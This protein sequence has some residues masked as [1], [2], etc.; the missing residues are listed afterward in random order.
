MIELEP[1][2]IYRLDVIGP[3]E[4]ADGAAATIHTA[5]AVM[6]RS[7]DSGVRVES[8]VGRVR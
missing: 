2:M 4:A 3:V 5:V 1:A 7:A 8:L 6:S